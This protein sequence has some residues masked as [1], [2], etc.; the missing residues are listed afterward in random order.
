M[1]NEVLVSA[2]G[3]KEEEETRRKYFQTKFATH[4]SI[5]KQDEYV[6]EWWIINDVEVSG[7][8]LF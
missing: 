5:D 7:C 8:V 1:R 2:E 3:K 4:H 6:C